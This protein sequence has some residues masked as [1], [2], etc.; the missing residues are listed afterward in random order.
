MEK[1]DEELMRECQE[2]GNLQMLEI[3]WNRY[4][5]RILSF[6]YRQLGDYQQAESLTQE[7]FYKIYRNSSQYLY[8]KKFS[9]WIFSIAR[10]LCTDEL[11]KR[12]PST[13][14]EFDFLADAFHTSSQTPLDHLILNEERVRLEEAIQK[15]TPLLRETLELRIY[16]KFSYTE[17]A[18][19][20]G[21]KESTIRSR[22]KYALEKL[23]EY[24]QDADSSS[25]PSQ[26]EQQ[27]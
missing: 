19:I 3:L 14:E 20:I 17:I 16:Q 22:M 9:N 21:G 13:Q 4:A 7:T 2:T 25:S 8:P 10:N 12:R 6:I 18:Q 1:A 5:S 15:L 27:T 24:L 11:R 26:A 23:A